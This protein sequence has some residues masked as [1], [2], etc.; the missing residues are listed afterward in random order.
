MTERV[1]LFPRVTVSRS[2][3]LAVRHGTIEDRIGYHAAVG[4]ESSNGSGSIDSEAA[5]CSIS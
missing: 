5:D 4:A 1:K 3:A 2:I